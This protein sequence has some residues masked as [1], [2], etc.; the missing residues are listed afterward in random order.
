M[1]KIYLLL[2]VLATTANAQTIN[3]PDANFKAKLLAASAVNTIAANGAT[4]YIKIDANNNNEIEVN[5]ALQVVTLNVSIADIYDLTGIEYFTNLRSLNC[6][7]NHIAALNVSTLTNLKSLLCSLNLLTTL[8]L[9]GLTQLTTLECAENTLTQI[10]FANATNIQS[11]NCKFN[12]LTTLDS[13]NLLN[14][15]TLQCDFNQLTSLDVS[16]LTQLTTLSCP[17]NQLTTLNLSLLVNLTLLNCSSNQLTA[18]ELNTLDNLLTL[19]CAHNQLTALDITNLSN[20]SLLNCEFNQIS[21]PL[22]LSNMPHLHSVYCQDNLISSITFTETTNIEVLECSA[23]QITELD[24]SLLSTLSII[25]C[26][27]NPLLTDLNIKNGSEE[28]FIN[29]SGNQNLVNIC[30]DATEITTVE[31]LIAEYGYTNCEVNSLCDLATPGF[32]ANTAILLYPNPAKDLLHLEIKELIGLKA[33]Y[34]YNLLGQ[35]VLSVP[36]AENGPTLDVSI[37]KTGSYFIKITTD[38]GTTSRKFV[39][40]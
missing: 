36:S 27:D 40:E 4:A 8:D 35:I 34:V 9:T 25:N 14:L 39:K 33:I 11:L 23:N 15:H 18:L 30:A 5:E 38:K 21:T 29:F 3:F 16:A 28:Q 17:S 1:K 22:H 10:N 13:S 37:L 26:H 31:N 20:L 2:L 32:D 7:Q 19:N 24:T 12:F 6:S